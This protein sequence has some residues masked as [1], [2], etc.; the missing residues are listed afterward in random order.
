MNIDIHETVD[1]LN[2]PRLREQFMREIRD[3]LREASIYPSS[4]LNALDAQL[5]DAPMYLYEDGSLTIVTPAL[6]EDGALDIDGREFSIKVQYIALRSEF[7]R[8][9][10]NAGK[11][12]W[13]RGP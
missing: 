5:L 2:D 1:S 4:T 11:V 8:V 12:V 6:G 9:D 7:S 10:F 3:K 13:S